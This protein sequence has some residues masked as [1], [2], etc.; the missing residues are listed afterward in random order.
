MSIELKVAHSE[1]EVD[2]ALWVRHEVFVIEDGKFGGKPLPGERVVDRFDAFP[3]VHN[4]VAYEND[5]AIATIR[6]V[7]ETTLGLPADEYYDFEAYRAE[8]RAEL[9]ELGGERL[10]PVLGSAGMLAVRKPWRARRDVVRAMFKVAAGVSLRE[11]ATHIVLVVNHETAAMYR[12]LGFRTLSERFWVEEIGNYVIPLA[13]SVESFY[14][15]AFGDLPKTPLDTFKDEFERVFLRAEEVLFSE[16]D[17]GDKAY[18]VNDGIVRISRTS[19]YGE[20]LNLANLT[21]GDLFGELALIDEG[22]RSATA[23]AVTDVELISLDREAFMEGVHQDPRQ[24]H[25]LLSLFAQ[26]LRQMDDFAMVL[27]YSPEEQRLQFAVHLARSQ[28][29]PDRKRPHLRIYRG[30]AD[31]IASMAAV[32]TPRAT[33]FLEGLQARGDIQCTARQIRFLR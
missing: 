30:T 10:E 22:R 8:A 15:W 11:G 19:P 3:G 2:D 18:I 9:Q 31:D 33:E 13:T 7:K 32:A 25:A 27:A 28:A 26:R 29:H 21:R 23:V 14:S 16:G 12:R 20:I 1:R 6:L 5:E 17:P 4:I 24:I